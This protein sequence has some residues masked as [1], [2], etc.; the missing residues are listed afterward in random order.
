MKLAEE[1]D[2]PD[3]NLLEMDIGAVSLVERAEDARRRIVE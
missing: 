3:R 2:D 1:S